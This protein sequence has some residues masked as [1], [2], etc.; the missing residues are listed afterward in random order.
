MDERPDP[1]AGAGYAM[2]LADT[3]H[4]WYRL[5]AARARVSYQVSE[6]LTLVLAAAVPVTAALSPGEAFL[7]AVLGGLV[8]VLTGLRTVY[9]WQENYLR[10]SAAREAIEHHR[11]LYRTG[12]PPYD[13]LF[14]RDK[15]LVARVSE[16]E[17][18]ETGQWI[19]VASER[20]NG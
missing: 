19:Q 3:S 2:T 20:P 12:A 4:E 14:E 6:C 16:I 15:V 13:D 9:H 7:P 17:H 11:R 10:F 5:H 8:V 18:V 1:V